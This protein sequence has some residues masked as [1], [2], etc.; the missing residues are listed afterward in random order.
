M[1]LNKP[2]DFYLQNYFDKALAQAMIYLMPYPKIKP[3]GPNLKIKFCLVNTDKIIMEQM[4][5]SS[6]TT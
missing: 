4:Q 1:P 6:L 5:G 3:N 2:L